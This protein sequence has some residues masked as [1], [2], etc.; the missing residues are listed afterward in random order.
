MLGITIKKYLRWQLVELLHV[1]FSSPVEV[2][3]GSSL[4]LSSFWA[5]GQTSKQSTQLKPPT[6]ALCGKQEDKQSLPVPAPFCPTHM[7]ARLSEGVNNWMWKD[8]KNQYYI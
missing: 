7:G 6:M 3:Y 4:T 8:M 2:H 5:G 1:I